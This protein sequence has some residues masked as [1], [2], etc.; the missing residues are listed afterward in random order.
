MS[1]ANATANRLL[2]LLNTWYANDLDQGSMATKLPDEVVRLLTTV[3]ETEE[4]LAVL[5]LLRNGKPKTFTARA[6]ASELSMPKATAES[7]LAM[8]CGRGFLTVTI[9]SDLFY[10]YAPI[11][12]NMDAPVGEIQETM[13]TDRDAVVA[14]LRSRRRDPVRTFAD[15]FVVRE[16]KKGDDDG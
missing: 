16:K 4:R 9:A 6:V 10:S 15:A 11:S 1:P 14:P 8:L 3:I 7:A 5:L 13:R 12:P 2:L